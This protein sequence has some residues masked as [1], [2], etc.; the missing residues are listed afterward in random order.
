L[1]VLTVSSSAAD[2][3]AFGCQARSSV[4]VESA[5]DPERRRK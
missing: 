1:R 2:T 5:R 4:T 3:I